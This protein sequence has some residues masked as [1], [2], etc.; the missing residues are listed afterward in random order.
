MGLCKDL[1]PVRVVLEHVLQE[2]NDPDP[3]Q[4]GIGDNMLILM[5]WVFE[6]LRQQ[7]LLLLHMLSEDIAIRHG[8]SV[9]TKDQRP[10]PPRT[11]DPGP[12]TSGH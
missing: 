4:H 1:G 2:L 12:N 7:V 3:L 8:R 9:K 5:I 6:A 10:W 11:K